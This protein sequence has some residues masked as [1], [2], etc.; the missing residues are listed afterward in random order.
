MAGLLTTPLTPVN[1]AQAATTGTFWGT[2]GTAPASAGIDLIGAGGNAFA[3]TWTSGSVNVVL[4]PNTSGNV[5]LWY[6]CG[7][8]AAGIAQV[9]VG[10]AVAGQVLPAATSQTIAANSSGWL[11]PYSPAT[12]NIRTGNPVPTSIAGSPT[13]AS[14][15]AAAA[16]CYAVAFTTVTNLYVRAYSFNNVQP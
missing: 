5:I 12:Y 6:Y 14:W 15:P 1:F 8:A 10:Q 2:G 13:I 16:G 3:Q 9:L 11:G 7:T 4:V